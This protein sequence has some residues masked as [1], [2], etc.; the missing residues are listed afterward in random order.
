MRASVDLPL[1]I[2]D[3]FKVVRPGRS[4]LHE[5]CPNDDNSEITKA[6]LITTAATLLG[7]AMYVVMVWM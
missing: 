7:M 4:Y 2:S 3:R 1:A 6:L 5:T